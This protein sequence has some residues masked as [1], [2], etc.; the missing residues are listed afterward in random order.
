MTWTWKVVDPDGAAWASLL[1]QQTHLVFH[2]P[3]WA[4]VLA[5]GVSSQ[6]MA[7]MLLQ[8]EQPK[9]GALGFLISLGGVRIAYFNY[10]YGSLFGELPSGDELEKLLQAFADQYRVCQIQFLGH[11]TA[12]AMR[13]PRMEVTEDQTQLS[14]LAGMTAEDLWSGYRRSRRQDLRKIRERGVKIET[15]QTPADVA[16]VHRCYLETMQR[17]G[18]VARYRRQLLQAIVDHCEPA[19][20]GRIYVARKDERVIAGMVIVESDGLSHGL[21]LAAENDARAHQPNKLL[22]HTALEEAIQRGQAALDYMPSGKSA[23]GVANFKDLWGAESIP[24]Q[25]HTLVTQPV[26]ARLWRLAYA[27]AG[28]PPMRRLI[29][30][31]RRWRS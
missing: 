24:I 23:R 22:L 10:P 5:R 31:Y 26:R 4:S 1:Q 16:E 12:P 29:S 27:T 21:L 17:T 18:G 30:W 25:H 28:S 2:E 6:V 3:V 9:A 15:A 11:S 13:G 8:D 19:G 20:C 14:Q 7:L